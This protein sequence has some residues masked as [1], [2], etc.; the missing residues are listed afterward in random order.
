MVSGDASG[1]VVGIEHVPELTDKSI[2]DVRG[3]RWAADLWD[4]GKLLLL[5][6]CRVLNL[7]CR[8][9]GWTWVSAMLRLF[10]AMISCSL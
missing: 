7:G 3:M 2:Q 8:G 10:M 1:S 4:K 5:Q 9:L 6:V